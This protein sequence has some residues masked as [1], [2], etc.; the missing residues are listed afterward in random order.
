MSARARPP[1]FRRVALLGIGLI[2]GSLALVMRRE[3]LAEEIV[4]C[5]R[6]EATLAT[7]RRLGLADRT[8]TVPREAVAGADL[9]VL[10]TPVGAA[11]PVAEAMAPGLAAGAIVTDVGSIKADVIRAVVPHLAEPARFVGGHPVAGTEHSGPEAAFDTLF[12][13]RHCILT[14]IEDTD[15]DAV[16]TVAAMWRAAGSMVETMTPEHHDRVLAITSHLPHLIAYT[17]V[18]TVADLEQHLQSEVLRYAAGGFT[19][20]TRIAASDPVMWRDVF[21]HNREAV[22][23]MLGRFTEDLAALQ[24]AIRWGEGDK[25]Q[26]LFTRTRTI[27]RGVIAEG[28][29]YDRHVLNGKVRRGERDEPDAGRDP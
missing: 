7:A 27:R 3:G 22:L 8:T 26:D 5:A 13:R 10:G 17:I 6:T 4:A 19:D 2:N 16:Q 9:V 11:G 14:P 29:A 21:L 1:R 18:A 12:A 23:E 24:R 28:Q 15:P 20:F 25:L